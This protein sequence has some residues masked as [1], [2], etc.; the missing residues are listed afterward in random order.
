M[1]L[2]FDTIGEESAKEPAQPFLVTEGGGLEYVEM[3]DTT[4]PFRRLRA[5]ESPNIVGR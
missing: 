5:V 1:N 2:D 3:F 4:I